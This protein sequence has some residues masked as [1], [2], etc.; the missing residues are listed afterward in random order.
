[1]SNYIPRVLTIAG[2]DSGG[3]AG[4]QAD[5]KTLTAHKVYGLS[6]IT[7]L[8]AQNTLGVKAIYDLP[9]DFIKIQIDTVL[10]DIGCD[11][12]KIGMLSNKE[13]I[14][15]VSEKISD[16][17]LKNVILDPVMVATS[18]DKLLKDDS[19]N[20]LKSLLI[21]LSYLLTP[22]I[23]EAELLTN[24]TIN[25]TDD[26]KKAAADIITLGCKYVLI[27]GGHLHENENALDILYD[28]KKF[29]KFSARRIKTKN[30]HGTGCTYSSAIAANLAKNL[31][32]LT[33]I[34]NAKNYVTEAISNSF[35]IGE[36]NGPLN[37]YWNIKD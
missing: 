22:N 27:K 1:M 12:V 21:P 29:Y 7:S 28:G 32:L 19:I 13:N 37:H 16:Y 26:M 3:G 11:S 36:G 8:T 34:S 4:I 14:K 35:S 30:T 6:V 2:S 23:R 31:D 9:A 20:V 15:L 33:S 5:L 17:E 25:S 18:G 24:S 10:K